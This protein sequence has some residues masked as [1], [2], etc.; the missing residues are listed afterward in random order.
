MC[1]VAPLLRWLARLPVRV[2]RSTMARRPR[3]SKATGGRMTDQ[4]RLPK[5]DPIAMAR[6]LA[7]VRE[8]VLSGAPAPVEP[9]SVVS[10]SWRRSLA[11][12]IDPERGTPPQV[13]DRREIHEIRSGH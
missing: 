7:T 10:D 11:A 6:V 13:Y 8:A 1:V 5:G 12:S 4:P 2:P 3:S 9:R